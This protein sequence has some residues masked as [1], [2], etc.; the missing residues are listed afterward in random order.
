MFG[1][2]ITSADDRSCQI[3]KDKAGW[4][5]SSDLHI[6]VYMST[7]IPNHRVKDTGPQNL[8]FTIGK[9]VLEA[10]VI[11]WES[12]PRNSEL[13]GFSVDREWEL[14]AWSTVPTVTVIT[15][16]EV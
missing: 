8:M 2:L 10:G 12:A 11:P 14:A 4:H 16:D 13:C 5:G 9:H 15:H 7:L 3:E 6:C 1:K